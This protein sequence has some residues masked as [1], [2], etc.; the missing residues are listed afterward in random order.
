LDS[1]LNTLMVEITFI[2]ENNTLRYF[3]KSENITFVRTKST[4]RKVKNDHSAKSLHTVTKIVES[5]KSGNKDW[6]EFWI[7]MSNHMINSYFF[8][9]CDSNG[10]YL[11]TMEMV[12][13][14]TDINKIQGEKRLLD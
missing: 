8:A 3:N 2:N 6:A 5:F 10:K 14:I 7:Y 13:D 12:E 1:L 11:G 9:I 4:I